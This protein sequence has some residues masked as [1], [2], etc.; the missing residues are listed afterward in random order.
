MLRLK[1]VYK[2]YKI[3]KETISILNDINMNIEAGEF[4]A[5]VGPSGCGKTTLLNL[6]SGIDKVSSGTIEFNNCSMEKFGDKERSCWRRNHIGYVFQQFNLIEFMTARQNIELVLQLNGLN[7]KER[8]ERSTELLKLV[9]LEERGRHLPSQL[10]GGQKQRVAIARAIANNPS[11]LLADEPTGALDSKTAA[12][13]MGILKKINQQGNVTIIMVTHDETIAAQAD[14]RISLLDGK[15]INDTS[16]SKDKIEKCVE[17]ETKKK[18]NAG[19]I[20]AMAVKNLF[21]KKKRAIL[22]SLAT[23]IGITGVVISFGIGSGAKAKILTEIGY[24]VNDQVVDVVESDIKLDKEAQEMILDDERVLNIYPND[25]PNVLCGYGENVCS[26][27]TQ[28]I[29]PLDQPATYWQENLMYGSLPSADNANEAIITITMAEKLLNN[30]EDVQSLLDKEMDMVF[31]AEAENDIPIQVHRKIVIKGIAGKAFLGVT[32]MVS[33]PYLLSQEVVKESL[34]QSD[35][36]PTNYCVTVVDKKDARGVKDT[37]CQMGYDASI[38]EDA[39]GTIGDMI[40]AVVA[41]IMLLAG[42]ALVVAG[43][44]IALITYMGVIERTREIGILRALGFTARDVSG[45][46]L[47]EGIIIGMC[48]GILGMLSATVIGNLINMVIQIMY[49][50]AD[51]ALYQ[52]NLGQMLFCIVFSVSIGMICSISPARKAAKMQPVKALGYVE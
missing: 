44:M 2:H 37:L 43:I 7:R 32:E 45:I 23:A 5:I 25:R 20:W 29:G 11:I 6:L 19:F 31:M 1:N 41:V 38:D 52:V 24:V 12:E 47:I 10:S 50:N 35:Y 4:V 16:T 26:G 13:I 22:T 27:L 3:S 28:V 46:F 18:N 48:S 14:R 49:E 34:Q 15:I 40:N 51:V 21:T 8:K 9:D 39:L 36:K 33:I 30:Q 17:K 42:I